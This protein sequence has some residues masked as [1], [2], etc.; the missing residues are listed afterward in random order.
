MDASMHDGSPTGPTAN[1]RP[2]LAMS[3]VRSTPLDSRPVTFYRMIDGSWQQWSVVEIDGA[4]VPGSHG[5]RCLI[6]ARPDCVRRVW[7]YPSDWRALDDEAL[8]QLSWHR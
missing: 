5:A 8:L 3:A 2:Q 6:F 7:D 1:A 4:V